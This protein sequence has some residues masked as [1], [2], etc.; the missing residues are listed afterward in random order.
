[1]T[2][3]QSVNMVL[4]FIAIFIVVL[5]T[6]ENK[7]RWRYTVTVLFV[8]IHM[9]V[10]YLVLL[11]ETLGFVTRPYADFFTWWSAYLR[12]HLLI[13]VIVSYCILIE[14]RSFSTNLWKILKK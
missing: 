6:I 9:L 4:T 12:T 2:I 8:L 1:M 3:T 14:W 7:D 10:F 5:W 11:I 13:S